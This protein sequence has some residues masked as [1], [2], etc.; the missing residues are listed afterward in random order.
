MVCISF[1]FLKLYGE[2]LLIRGG[3]RDRDKVELNG[4][5]FCKITPVYIFLR[6]IFN[7]SQTV[8][9]YNF[10]IEI[11]FVAPVEIRAVSSCIF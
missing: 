4:Y 3:T 11:S 5:T 10:W 8:S 9:S 1:A 2:K 6:R 7:G